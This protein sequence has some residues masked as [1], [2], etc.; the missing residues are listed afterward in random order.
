[1]M[2]LGRTSIY[3][4]SAVM[5]LASVD[6][7]RPSTVQE[8]ADATGMPIE[9]LRKL[10]GR[11]LRGRIIRSVRGRKGG[12]RLG[13]STDRITL[14]AIVE[15]IEGP[16]D[17]AA[18][19]EEGLLLFH[20]RSVAKAIRHWRHQAAHV[21]RQMLAQTSVADLLAAETESVGKN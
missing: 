12:F 7:S 1:M 18:V 2:R 10:L 15:A 6:S 21:I 9:Y 8:I 3:G 16:V 14:L 11:L 20:N 13:K 17:D 19:F 5:Y 4:L